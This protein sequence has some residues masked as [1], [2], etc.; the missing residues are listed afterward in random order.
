MSLAPRPAASRTNSE[1]A[2]MFASIS[3][4]KASWRAAAWILV[5]T[6]RSCGD[7]LADA[8]EAAAAGQDMVGAQAHRDPV[9]EERADRPDGFGIVRRAILRDDDGGIADVEVHV[10]GGDDLALA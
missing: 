1:T 10:G 7:L 4:V 2:A 5:M 9:R 8:M 6:G 3:P